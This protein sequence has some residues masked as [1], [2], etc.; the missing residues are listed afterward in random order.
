MTPTV[1]RTRWANPYLPGQA[2]GKARL[3]RWFQRQTR[4]AWGDNRAAEVVAAAE[5]TLTLWG[6]RGLDFEALAA[7]IAVEASLAL[8]LTSQI[9]QLEAGSPTCT[10]RRI[11]RHPAVCA[12]RRGRPCRP[13]LWAARERPAVHELAAARSFSGFVPG[14]GHSG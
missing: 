3:G 10:Q 1:C 13:D 2:D 5:T 7:D 8:E 9:R 14:S 4:R 12:G 6:P 11:P